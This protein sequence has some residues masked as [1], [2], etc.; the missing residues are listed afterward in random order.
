MGLPPAVVVH[1]IDHARAALRPGRAALLLS[2]P[3]A[4]CYAGAGWWRAL[5][6]AAAGGGPCPPDAIDCDDQPGRALEALAA[7]CRIVILHPCPAFA[8]VA[9]RAGG[10]MVL[11]ERP[12][13]LD[14]RFPGAERRL[15]AWLSGDKGAAIG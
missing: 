10:A 8:S 7:G 2:G 12:A 13:A 15:A 3:G 14:L 4:G 11:P 5:V 1:G 9:A 6:A